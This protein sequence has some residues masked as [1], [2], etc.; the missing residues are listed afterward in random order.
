MQ[1]FEVDRANGDKQR[2]HNLEAYLYDI[3][4]MPYFSFEVEAEQ[5]TGSSPNA[6]K[7][8]LNVERY[9]LLLANDVSVYEGL[10]NQFPDVEASPVW[11][12]HGPVEMSFSRKSS[13]SKKVIF[14]SN[15]HQVTFLDPENPITFARPS[16]YTIIGFAYRFI[17]TPISYLHQ[18]HN[19][20]DNTF[21]L[22]FLK[23]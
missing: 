13:S 1:M 11:T 16:D 22:T 7:A 19:P 5:L 21:Q 18:D 4:P 14:T 20:A 2:I 8:K 9:M 23:P 10:K 15:P 6:G 3:G 12:Y 17:L